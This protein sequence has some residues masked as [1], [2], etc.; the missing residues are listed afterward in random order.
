MLFWFVQNVFVA[1]YIQPE[2]ARESS[3]LRYQIITEVE[4]DEKSTI[5]PECIYIHLSFPGEVR[6]RAQL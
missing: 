4:L 6:G 2:L 1:S 5:L 3:S